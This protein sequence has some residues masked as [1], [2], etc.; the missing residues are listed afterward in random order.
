M[1]FGSYESSPQQAFETAD[2]PVMLAVGTDAQFRRLVE[3]RQQVEN[4]LRE[5]D[6]GA[7]V[8]AVK[9]MGQALQKL[10]F[11][12]V[13]PK[14]WLAR[15]TGK[16]KEEAAGFVGQVEAIG[17]A[18]ED[19]QDE[20]KALQRRQ[21]ALNT[22]LDKTLVE[23]DVEARAIE[24]IIDQGARWLQDMRNQLKSRGASATDAQGQQAINDAIQR[25]ATGTGSWTDLCTDT[26]APYSCSLST[27]GSGEVFLRAVAVDVADGQTLFGGTNFSTTLGTNILTNALDPRNIG[28]GL[29]LG[30]IRGTLTIPGT[31]I[32][33]ANLQLLARALEGDS[34]ANVLSTP[35]VLTLAPEGAISAV[36]L[37]STVLRPSTRRC[38]GTSRG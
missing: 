36:N 31:D 24:K 14:G 12:L 37:T 35:N 5:R 28:T 4:Q 10:D 17:R 3:L 25:S 33:I 6:Y 11:N 9:A 1:P 2:R 29:N 18:A 22:N 21:Q 20:V 34:G 7:V 26:T 23:F 27:S 19:L 8:A 13:Q 16:G 15:A 38:C 32:E 30:I